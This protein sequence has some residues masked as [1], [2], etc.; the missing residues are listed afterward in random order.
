MLLP[1]RQ[2][3]HQ[4]ERQIRTAAE[5]GLM[6]AI[7]VDQCSKSLEFYRPVKL[8]RRH[9]ANLPGDESDKDQH[10]HQDY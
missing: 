3:Q 1:A 7:L 2:F 10:Y 9:V 6:V 4:T 8:L 5:D